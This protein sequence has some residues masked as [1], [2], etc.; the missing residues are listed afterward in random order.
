MSD[1]T[2]EQ[3]EGWAIVE[4]MGRRRIDE[5]LAEAAYIA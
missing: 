4:I 5:Q 2:G 1:D 3:Y